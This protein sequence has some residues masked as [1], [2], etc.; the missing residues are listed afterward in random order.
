MIKKY[1]SIKLILTFKI[2]T[3]VTKIIAHWLGGQLDISSYL[4]FVYYCQHI[5]ISELCT[6]GLFSD[7]PLIPCHTHLFS[8]SVL[9]HW[10]EFWTLICYQLDS[11]IG[12][13]MSTQNWYQSGNEQINL[14][15][16]HRY[17]QGLTDVKCMVFSTVEV[18]SEQFD[19]CKIVF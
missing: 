17:W 16:I 3:F 18:L 8:L 15:R 6:K 2:I 5:D 12:V 19:W 11:Y 4:Y 1:V 7:W 13:L 10:Q 9:L 14:R